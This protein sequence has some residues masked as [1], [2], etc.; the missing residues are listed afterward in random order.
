MYLSPPLFLEVKI[1]KNVKKILKLMENTRLAL[2]FSQEIRTETRISHFNLKGDLVGKI[3]VW[4]RGLGGGDVPD[5]TSE[6][7]CVPHYTS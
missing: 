6:G 3:Y 4:R 1:I 2:K 5:Y 7:G